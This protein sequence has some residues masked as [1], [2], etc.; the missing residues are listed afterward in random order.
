MHGTLLMRF[1]PVSVERVDYGTAILYGPVSRVVVHIGKQTL[2]FKST[3]SMFSCS[4]Y[5]SLG[6][7]C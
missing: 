1:S 4:E 7:L 5:P 6:Q 2:Q 3:N